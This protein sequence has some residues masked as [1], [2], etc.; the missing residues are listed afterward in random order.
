MI[1]KEKVAADKLPC[2]LKPFINIAA[3]PLK[4]STS[5]DE[6]RGPARGLYGIKALAAKPEGLSLILGTQMLEDN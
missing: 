5:S 3:V 2:I 4:G 6:C 1:Q